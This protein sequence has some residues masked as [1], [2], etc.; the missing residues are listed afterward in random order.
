MHDTAA[1]QSSEWRV[2]ARLSVAAK[3]LAIGAVVAGLSGCAEEKDSVR[4]SPPMRPRG[5]KPAAVD[6]PTVENA[7]DRS[8]EIRRVCSR[9]A[10]VELPRCWSEEYDRTKDRKFKGNVDVVLTITPSGQAQEVEVLNPNPAHSEFEK[11]VSDS[12]RG[13]TYPSGQTLA[14]VQCHFFLQSSM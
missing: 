3:V 12:A 10:S 2:R 6:T 9:K 7:D 13:W 1:N 5:A 14:P 11:C 4:P 8:E